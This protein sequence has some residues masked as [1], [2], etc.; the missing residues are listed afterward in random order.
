MKL[1]T[2]S[3][4]GRVMW[5]PVVEARLHDVSARWPTPAAMVAASVEPDGIAALQRAADAAYSYDVDHVRLSPPVPEPRRILCIGINYL[6][7]AAETGRP[8][9]TAAHP[10]V[11]TR[12]PSSFVG[13]G[14]AVVRPAASSDFDYEGELAVVIGR[15]ARSIPVARALDAVAGY[16]CFMDGSVRDFQRHSTQFTAGKNF[17]ASGSW[18]PWIVTADEVG[19]PTDLL[20]TTVVNGSVVQHASTALLI[21]DVA[22]IVA[23]CSVFTTL[24]PGDVIATGTPGGVGAARTPPLWLTPGSTVEVTIDRVGTLRNQV[25]AEA[26]FTPDSEPARPPTTTAT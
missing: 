13:H 14:Q 4:D 10:T 12:F 17:D 26:G 2:G 22:A 25:V 20:L 19:P 11:F 1:A 5:G 15:R 7:H 21:H 9:E 24:E 18:G 3:V 6:D 23:Y 8:V 16:S